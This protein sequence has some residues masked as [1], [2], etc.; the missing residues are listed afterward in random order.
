MYTQ[1]WNSDLPERPGGPFALTP[2]VRRF[3]I[4]FA[5]VHLL[6]MTVLTSDGVSEIFAFDASTAFEQPWTFITYLFLHGGLFHLAVNCLMLFFFGPQVEARLGSNNF[7]KYFLFCGAGGAFLSLA[8]A[9]VWPTG[10]IVGASGS[11][12][13][14][15]IA[16]AVFWPNAMVMIFPFPVP[17]KAKWLVI[18]AVSL[19]MFFQ[20]VGA[21][22]GTAHLAHIGGAVFGLLY[23]RGLP[24]LADRTAAAADRKRESAK[25]LVH[26]PARSERGSDRPR[27]PRR[28]P[29]EQDD[30]DR[31]LDKISAS[32][33]ESLT[34]DE[35][36]ILDER[37]QKLRS[38]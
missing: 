18:G 28:S 37:S 33:L 15:A 23:L 16:F 35:R 14:V 11:I 2:W 30:V 7:A 21:R 5:A 24:Y 20:L 17:I 22:T 38:R 13:G 6:Q 19:A 8:L 27:R 26:R 12:F 31:I 3:L 25:V 29:T 32:G 1:E 10:Y 4:A 36:R 34:S 9:M